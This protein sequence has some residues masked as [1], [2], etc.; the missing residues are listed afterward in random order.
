MPH[1][2]GM[3]VGKRGAAISVCKKINVTKMLKIPDIVVKNK[4]RTRYGKK[5]KNAGKC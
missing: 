5:D 2:H 1:S 3:Q 4:K